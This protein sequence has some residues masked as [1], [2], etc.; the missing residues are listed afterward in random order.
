[1]EPLLSWY[2]TVGEANWSSPNELKL[3]YGNASLIGEKRVVFNIHGN[4]HRLI[5][6]IEYR[7]KI[8]F[9]VWIG[10]HKE[11][12]KIDVKNISYESKSDK[13]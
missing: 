4:S 13:K 11:Y 8:V 9:I 5:V 3:Q 10:T 2:D 12:D 1:M 7:M 6:D